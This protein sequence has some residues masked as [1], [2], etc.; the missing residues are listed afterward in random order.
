MQLDVADGDVVARV[1]RDL[2]GRAIDL[3]VNNAGVWGGERQ[4]LPDIDFDGW[5]RTLDVNTLGPVRVSLAL[6]PNIEA[7]RGRRIVALT[8]GL[9]S[10]GDNTAGRYYA[11]RSRKAGLNAVFRSLALD[12]KGRGIAVAVLSPGWARTDMGGP[13]ATLSAAESVADMRRVI[14]G[15]DLRRSGG[16]YNVDGSSLPW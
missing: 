7:G 14:E 15:L 2:G 8:S 5:M 13:D 1:A 6:L 4:H 12:L 3:L 16:F 9:G 11:Y 10:I